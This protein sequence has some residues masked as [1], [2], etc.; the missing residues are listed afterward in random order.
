[1]DEYSEYLYSSGRTLGERRTCSLR[2]DVRVDLRVDERVR[3]DIMS[4]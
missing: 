2:E 1:M 4:L 3:L